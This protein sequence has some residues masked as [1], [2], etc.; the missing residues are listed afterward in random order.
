MLASGFVARTYLLGWAAGWQRIYWY[1]W[2]AGGT[3]LTEENGGYKICEGAYNAVHDWTVGNRFVAIDRHKD[4]TWIVSLRS[5]ADKPSWVLWNESVRGHVS[6]PTAWRATTATDLAGA[7]TPVAGETDI[8]PLPI[9]L[10]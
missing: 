6:I 1:S 10:Q 2:N 7:R 5:P 8:S 9:L 3:T 4:G